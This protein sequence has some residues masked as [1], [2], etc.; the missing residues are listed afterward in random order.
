LE[1]I[2]EEETMMAA[3][4]ASTTRLGVQPNLQS[5]INSGFTAFTNQKYTNFI[6]ISWQ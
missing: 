2:I 6:R 4:L 3:V 1:D 5:P